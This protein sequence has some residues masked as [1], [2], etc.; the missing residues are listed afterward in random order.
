MSSYVVQCGPKQDCGILGRVGADRTFYGVRL[1]SCSTL[2]MSCSFPHA[3]Y[4]LDKVLGLLPTKSLAGVPL[5]GAG[6]VPPVSA[7]AVA[8]AAVSAATD[9][10]IPAGVLDVWQIKAYEGP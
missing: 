4:P 9:P 5:L 8:R 7:A 2:G 6:F 3:G 10:A 1:L